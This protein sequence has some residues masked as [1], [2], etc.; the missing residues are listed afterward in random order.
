ME[1]ALL[2]LL[3]PLAALVLLAVVEAEVPRRNLGITAHLAYASLSGWH[4]NGRK[5]S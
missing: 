2:E 5:F 1:V 4:P 3:K